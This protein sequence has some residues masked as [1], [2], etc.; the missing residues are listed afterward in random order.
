MKMMKTKKF[1]VNKIT[2]LILALTL[3]SAGGTKERKLEISF[4]LSDIQSF[5]PSYQMAIWIEK[6][7]GSFVKTLF[8][9]EYLSYGGYN[10]PEI[11]HEWS[12]KAKWEEATKEEF[13]AVTGATPGTGE[14]TLKLTCPG[15]LL[16]DGK[17]RIF[18]EVHLVDEYNELYS[19]EIDVTK[20]KSAGELKV[21]Y[22]P[23]KC[24]KKTEG[25]LMTGVFVKLK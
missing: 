20:K 13:D 12:S 18:A 1:I 24:Q 5:A 2:L 17:Y 16:P 10:L 9:S 14:V 4:L 6:A 21:S 8:I 22:I 7:D 11:C 15:D 3:V 25:D 19:A 23:G